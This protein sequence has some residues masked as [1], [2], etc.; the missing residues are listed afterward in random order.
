[1]LVL[2]R[3]KN[4]SIVIN[5]D[6][7]VTVVEIRGDKV[8]LGIVA[9]KEVPVHRQEVFDAIHGKARPPPAGPT[10]VVANKPVDTTGRVTPW[11]PPASTPSSPPAAPAGGEGFVFSPRS[12]GRSRL[13]SFS[14][15]YFRIFCMSVSR[16]MPSRLAACALFAARSGAMACADGAGFQLLQ[17]QARQPLGQ[18]RRLGAERCRSSASMHVAVA[19]GHGRLQHRAQLAH[20]AGPGVFCTAAATPPRVS[21]TRPAVLDAQPAQEVLH[22]RRDVLGVVAQRR[23]PDGGCAAGRTGPGGSGRPRPRG[24]VAVGGGDDAHVD[25]DLRRRRPP[26]GSA[27]RLQHAQQLGLALQRQLADLVEE[28]RARR[29]PARRGRR[30]CSVAPVKAPLSWPNSSASAMRGAGWR[31]S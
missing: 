8:R 25:L 20:V 28:Q 9:P 16:W 15:S 3:K 23:H 30:G 1:M 2:S 4:E 11:R 18:L 12:T 21:R 29:R 26:A 10:A 19:H 22:Q 24:Q 17:V 7:T 6:I 31:R 27:C 13:S 14:I 5:N